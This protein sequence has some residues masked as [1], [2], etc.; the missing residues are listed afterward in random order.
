MP[1]RILGAFFL[2]AGLMHFV[3]PAT[4]AA[5]VPGALPRKREIV[6]VTLLAATA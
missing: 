6:Y 4:Y 3:K 5:I 2:A 1:A